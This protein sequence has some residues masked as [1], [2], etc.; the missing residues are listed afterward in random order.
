V[1]EANGEEEHIELRVRPGGVSPT[2]LA[3]QQMRKEQKERE[4]YQK[5]RDEMFFTEIKGLYTKLDA[6]TTEIQGQREEIQSLKRT[7]EQLQLEISK[8]PYINPV[9][10]ATFY[11]LKVEIDKPPETAGIRAEMYKLAGRVSVYH[12]SCFLFGER[13]NTS[14]Y[15][16]V[17]P[18]PFG[19]GTLSD[20]AQDT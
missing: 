1:L 5:E 12:E 13:G 4:Q 11:F 2:V 7:T 19:R 14:D 18:L 20:R 10:E 9:K 3:L 15:E 8:R 16:L 17:L 6:A